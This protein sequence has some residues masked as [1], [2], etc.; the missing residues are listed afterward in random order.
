[1]ILMSQYLIGEIP[2]K[3]VYF[4]G[5]VRTADGKKM[6]KSLGEKQLTR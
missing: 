4:H 3:T 2:F 6:S 5:M 1:M